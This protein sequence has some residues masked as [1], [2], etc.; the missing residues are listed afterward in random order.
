MGT[1]VLGIDYVL[2]VENGFAVLGEG[3]Q[4][5]SLPVLEASLVHREIEV[6]LERRD[7][8]EVVLQPGRETLA[9]AAWASHTL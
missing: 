7:L 8:P 6:R 3:S 4:T 1:E 9:C 2:D 5:A